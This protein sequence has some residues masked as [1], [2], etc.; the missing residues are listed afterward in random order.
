MKGLIVSIQGYSKTTTQELARK[1]INHGA[2]G[3]RT[4]Q[5][6]KVKAPII[7]LKKLHG[8]EYYITT[9]KDIIHEVSKWADYV[10]IDSR[11]GNREIEWLYAHCHTSNIN[12]VAD[13][14][15][16][17]D[18]ENILNICYG[19]KIKK[20]EYFATTFSNCYIN[21]ITEVPIIAEGGY[22]SIDSVTRAKKNGAKC[23][24]IGTALDIGILS[25]IYKGIWNEYC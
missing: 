15:K 2:T 19:L 16:I 25:N 5:S 10:A 6:I 17:E 23:V 9:D 21:L 1:A 12:I 4:D 8:K 7:G 18:V 24:C 13:I 14:E 11:K 3:I 20:P 22:S